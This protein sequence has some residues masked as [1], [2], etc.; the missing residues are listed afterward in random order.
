MQAIMT[1]ITTTLGVSI[2]LA[3]FAASALAGGSYGNASK[4]AAAKSEAKVKDIVQTAQ[5]AGSFTTLLKAVHVAGLTATLKG[6]GPFT[7]FAPTDEAFAKLPA[8]ALDALLKDRE[9]LRNVL[10]Y[11]VA[12]GALDAAAVSGMTTIPTAG[13]GMLRVDATSGVRINDAQVVLPNVEASNGIIHVIDT[14]LLPN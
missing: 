1:C 3:G 5:G 12:P 9:A 2:L 14:V 10:L 13:G 6:D 7:V 4:D 11:H 8:G